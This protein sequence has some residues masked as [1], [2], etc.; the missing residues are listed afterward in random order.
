VSELAESGWQIRPLVEKELQG[1]IERGL[2]NSDIELLLGD[3][4]QVA[5]RYEQH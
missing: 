1:W 3:V 2:G 4:L 5:M